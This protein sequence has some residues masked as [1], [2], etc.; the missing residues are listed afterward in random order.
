MLGNVFK[1]TIEFGFYYYIFIHNLLERIKLTEFE[2]FVISLFVVQLFRGA[3]YI[4]GGFIIAFTEIFIL[5][6]LIINNVSKKEVSQ[7]F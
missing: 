1:L 7:F 5:K 4:N 3:G 6:Y 2:I